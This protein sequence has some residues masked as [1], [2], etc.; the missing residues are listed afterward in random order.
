VRWQLLLS[1]ACSDLR[2]VNTNGKNGNGDEASRHHYQD[3]DN[4]LL[5]L[6]EWCGKAAKPNT[7]LMTPIAC[8]P[9]PG[10]STWWDFSPARSHPRQRGGGS[11]YW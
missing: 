7:R 4:Q 11:G 9:W 2:S 1:Y 5:Q 6:R 8:S 10:S 3:A